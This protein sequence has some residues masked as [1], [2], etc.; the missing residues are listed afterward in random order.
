[1]NEPASR[2]SA[3][4]GVQ[5][6]ADYDARWAEMA[7]RG[8]A[9]HGEADRI[10]AYGPRSVLDA[11]CGTGR[12]AIELARRGLDVVGV[13]LDVRMLDEARAKAPELTWV[14]GDLV[15]V[16]LGRTFDVVAMPGNVMIFV[17]PG[18]EAVVVA[19]LARH[20]APGGLL[21]A[22]FQ[23]TGPYTLDA[24]DADCRAAGL[25]LVDRFA[26]WEGDPYDGGAYAVSVHDS[27]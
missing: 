7:A 1:V 15:D 9:V 23:L 10:A 17:R 5:R 21:I 2:W 16:A 24:Y 4:A 26:T 14:L 3:A 22:G 20:V 27:S 25:D 12:V 6:G 8:E 11:G 18:T 13:D 19:N